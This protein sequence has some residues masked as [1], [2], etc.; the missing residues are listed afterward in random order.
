MPVTNAL[1]I[2]YKDGFAEVTDAT[3]ITAYGRREGFLS[4]GSATT[5][6]D[7]EFVAAERLAAEKDPE[8]QITAKLEFAYNESTNLPYRG[9]GIGDIVASDD[10][11]GT[12][13]YRVVGLTVREDDHGGVEWV[14]ELSALEDYWDTRAENTLRRMSNGTL[15]GRSLSASP[16]PDSGAGIPTGKL[17]VSQVATFSWSGEVAA[18]QSGPFYFQRTTRLTK[19]VIAAEAAGTG[20]TTIAL[21]KNGTTFQSENL[22]SSDVEEWQGIGGQFFTHL[23]ALQIECTAAGGH[24]KVVV[25]VYGTTGDFGADSLGAAE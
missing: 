19:V 6:S 17:Q 24:N 2:R 4:A 20:T 14:P 25:T 7:A 12:N 10:D 11:T 9:F 16:T 18:E 8:T 23:D 22:T 21:Q 5:Q 3:S 15:G 1:L 13:D